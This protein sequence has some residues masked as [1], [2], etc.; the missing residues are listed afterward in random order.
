MLGNVLPTLLLT[1][2]ILSAAAWFGAMIYSLFVL[3]PRSQQYFQKSDDFEDFATFIAASARWK[4]LTGI[5]FIGTTGLLLWVA[6]PAPS[7][8]WVICMSLKALLLLIATALFGYTSWVL[9]PQRLCAAP[10]ERL[11]YQNIFRLVG[12]SLISICAIAF[13][14]S[15][16]AR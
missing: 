6:K 9:W 5:I 13:F 12:F 10:A 7:A 14:I 2:H 11:R 3:Q 8:F 4:V 1:A 16:L 15:V